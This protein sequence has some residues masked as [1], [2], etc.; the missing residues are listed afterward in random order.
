MLSICLAKN[1]LK[2]IYNTYKCIFSGKSRLEKC[3]IDFYYSKE[4]LI[5]L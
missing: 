5:F 1:A 3:Y 4:F 2:D